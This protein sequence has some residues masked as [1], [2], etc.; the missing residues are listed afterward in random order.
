MTK[1]ETPSTAGIV[2]AWALREIQAC[3]KK[4]RMLLAR[5]ADLIIENEKLKCELE[6]ARGKGHAN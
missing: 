5:I 2:P 1:N 4:N 6:K 3:Q